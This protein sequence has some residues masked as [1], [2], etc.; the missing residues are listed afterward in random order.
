MKIIRKIALTE[1]QSLFYSPIAWIVIIVFSVQTYSGIMEVIASNLRNSEMG[2]SQGNLTMMMLGAQPFSL[3]P[4]IMQWLFIFIPLLTMGLMSREL[5]S[6][7]I[8][9][10]YSS[11]VRNSQIILGK[12]LSMIVMALAMVLV[13]T[14]PIIYLGTTVENFDWPIAFVGLL[15]VFLLICTYSAIGLFMSSLTSYQ[16]VAMMGSVTALFLLGQ[17]SRWGQGIAFVRDITYW[18]NIS[19][20][21]ETFYRGLIS[22]EN[23]F[24][25]ILVMALFISLAVLRLKAIRQKAKGSVVWGK[26]VAVIVVFCMLGFLTS[27]PTMKLYYDATRTKQLT[28]TENS[29]GIIAQAEGPLEITTYVNILDNNFRAGLPQAVKSDERR[30]EMYTRFKPEIKMKYVYYWAMPEG[31]NLYERY[32]GLTDEQIVG[33]ICHTNDLDSTMFKPLSQVD[34]ADVLR[35]ENFRFV[36]LLKRGNGKTSLLRVFD[37]S[38]RFPSEQ[39]ISAALKRV[40]MDLPVVGFVAGNGERS[41]YGD[42][43]RGYSQFSQE[44]TFRYALLNQGFNVE[45]VTLDKSVPE[46]INIIVIADM[47]HAMNAEQEANLDA[48]IARGGNMVV[49]GER[50]RQQVMNPVVERLG[51]RFLP[52]QIVRR[53]GAGDEAR[54]KEL[55]LNYVATQVKDT[56]DAPDK[57]EQEKEDDYLSDFVVGNLTEKGATITYGFHSML[58]REEVVTMPGSVAIEYDTNHGFDVTRLF[59]SDDKD[60]WNEL[61]TTDFIDDTVR[62]NSKAGE[63]EG[64]LPMGITLTRTVND[65]EQ[66]ILVLGDSDCISNGEINMRRRNVNGGNFNMVMAAFFWLS[67]EEVP[68]DVRRPAPTDNKFLTNTDA[69][70]IAK[71][72]I[73]A[74]VPLLFAVAFLLIWLRRR[75]R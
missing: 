32:P 4:R 51:V 21:A 74:G 2:W 43:D 38:M 19:G 5:S 22:S 16:I 71:L 44:R 68:I 20:R 11:P 31:S 3:L 30:F 24:Y 72:F 52:G 26:Y 15:G 64:A 39:E 40:V 62:I 60:S 56:V 70:K 35:G 23:L 7:S 6:G 53:T 37:D 25:F 69:F 61:E 55:G 36:R 49:A 34:I 50:N 29:Q 12:F 66:K 33:R 9:L 1:L 46:H 47:R 42:G 58:T 75:G 8:K 63:K 14:I 73:I 13:L 10:L 45:E 57:G 17:V 54:M 18:L 59:M 41:I 65:R 27:R 67:D 28:L 48:Y